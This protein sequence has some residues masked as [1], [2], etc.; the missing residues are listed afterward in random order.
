MTLFQNQTYELGGTALGNLSGML[1]GAAALLGVSPFGIEPDILQQVLEKFQPGKHRLQRIGCFN[2]VTYVNDS[3]ATNTGAVNT[4]ISQIGG[5]IVLIA[6]GRGK[7][8]DYTLLRDSVAAHVKRL[9]LIGEA[10]QEIGAV[11]GDLV[12]VDYPANLSEAVAAAAAAAEAGDTVLFSPACASFDM[13]D[14]Y[15]HRGDCFIEAAQQ[16]APENGQG[17]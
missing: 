8:D 11:L 6:G 17:N 3:K 14:D 5:S 12:P 7:N 9:I 10:A 4:G 13:F 1:N 15:K 16:L 2:G